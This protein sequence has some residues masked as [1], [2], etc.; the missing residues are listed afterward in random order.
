V[1]A[2]LSQVRRPD[3]YTTFGDTIQRDDEVILFT[4][5]RQR[6][7]TL[8]GEKQGYGSASN[9]LN[10]TGVIRQAKLYG[11]SRRVLLVKR[12]CPTTASYRYS[13]CSP[14]ETTVADT[15]GPARGEG[16]SGRS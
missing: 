9:P 12:D 16:I 14:R 10:L 1:A 5:E 4:N 15:C 7:L 2:T 8:T 11:S 13:I 3:S 6:L